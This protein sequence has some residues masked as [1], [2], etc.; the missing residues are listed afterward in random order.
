MDEK[1]NYEAILRTPKSKRKRINKNKTQQTTFIGHTRKR[2]RKIRLTVKFKYNRYH[3]SMTW[4]RHNR[5]RV[6]GHN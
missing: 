5:R 1:E 4:K 3:V 2:K 6:E